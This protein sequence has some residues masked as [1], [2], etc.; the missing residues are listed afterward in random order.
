[1][2]DSIVVFGR[3]CPSISRHRPAFLYGDR[4]L[5]TVSNSTIPPFNGPCLAYIYAEPQNKNKGDIDAPFRRQVPL[6][7]AG[8]PTYEDA[9]IELS[10]R[11]HQ[12]ADELVREPPP[13]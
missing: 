5:L 8:G 6:A 10:A 11:L 4:V 13:L 3:V 1:M 12:L 9:L 7:Y 2:T